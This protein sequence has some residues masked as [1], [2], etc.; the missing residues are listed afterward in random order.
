[1]ALALLVASAYA[2][3]NTNTLAIFTPSSMPLA[4]VTNGTLLAD[5][6]PL[7]NPGVIKS[8]GQKVSFCWR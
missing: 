8:A 4:A 7:A 3:T 2:Q 5:R 1:M 6:L